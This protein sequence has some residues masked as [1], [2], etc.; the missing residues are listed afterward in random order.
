MQLK[1]PVPNVL[2][3]LDVNGVHL[4][5]R[6]R[7]LALIQ[8]SF[9]CV[10]KVQAH[11]TFLKLTCMQQIANFAAFLPVW[12]QLCQ[13]VPGTT[14]PVFLLTTFGYVLVRRRGELVSQVKKSHLMWCRG[15][16]FD[17]NMCFVRGDQP[18][19]F[20]GE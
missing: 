16:W 13:V 4:A 1:A 10:L 12:K 6:R 9:G 20:L 17:A 15:L 3:F 19:V 2:D 18:A 14:Q 7:E 8:A 5:A 11:W